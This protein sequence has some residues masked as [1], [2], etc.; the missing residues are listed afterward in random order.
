MVSVP[1][2]VVEAAG[3]EANAPAT[4]QRGVIGKVV[5]QADLGLYRIELFATVRHACAHCASAKVDEG[6]VP[7]CA[8]KRRLHLMYSP[9]SKKV[10]Q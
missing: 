2:K 7:R 8:G 1:P 9:P 6:R 10:P 5:G 3:L 4:E